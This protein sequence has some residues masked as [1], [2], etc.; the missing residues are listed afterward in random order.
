MKNSKRCGNYPAG[1][2]F[3]WFFVFLVLTVSCQKDDM[4]FDPALD[5]EH[6]TMFKST[7]PG[8]YTNTTGTCINFI[9]LPEV[10][11]W[12]SLDS[13]YMIFYAHGMVDPVPYEGIKLP[14]DCIGDKS[15]EE[16]ILANT[17]G[18]ASTSYSDNGLAVLDAVEDIKEL[19][20]I[21]DMFFD[22]HDEY[23]RPDMLF[24]GGP[25]EGGLVTIKTIEKYPH[26]FDGAI[27]IG[28]PIGDFWKQLQYMGDFHVLFNYFFGKELKNLGI[29]IG[30]P[31]V[32]ISTEIM[33]AWKN[34]DYRPQEWDGRNLQ[35]VLIGL[36]QNYPERVPQLLK[37]AKVTVDMNDPEA[38]GT[39]TLELLRFG[40]MLTNDIHNRMDGVPYDNTRKW[41]WGSDNDW[42]LNRSI[43]RIRADYGAKMSVRN[44]ETTGET[45]IPVVTIHTTGDHVVPFWHNPKYKYKIFLKGNS[46]LHTGI[47]VNNYGHCTIEEYHIMAGLYII[48]SKASL[49]NY[50]SLW[51]NMFESPGQMEKFREILKDNSIE[52]DFK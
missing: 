9:S 47:P 31:A 12:N 43:Q 44:Y 18:Y 36:M 23:M 52:V 51:G 35:E 32:T 29:D 16:I 50:F 38:M 7:A 42:R 22:E 49:I 14:D 5:I 45:E 2:I 3:L 25:S 6:N 13:R 24:L 26:T 48:I 15:V 27:S 19:V 33:D 39:V 17:M 10:E 37:C 1:K 41:Y 34:E 30:N 21:A 46:L 28:A 11:A 20:N 8:K 40:I 4:F